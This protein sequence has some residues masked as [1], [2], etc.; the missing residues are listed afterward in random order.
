MTVC[1]AAICERDKN[2]KIVVAGDRMVTYGN[3]EEFEQKEPK[4]IDIAPNCVIA[5]AGNATTPSTILYNAKLSKTIDIVNVREIGNNLLD[6]YFSTRTSEIENKVF[7]RYGINTYKEFLE[8]QK[9]L[10]DDWFLK[11]EEDF[12]EYLFDIQL[13]V[14][15][16]DENGPQLYKIEEG[17]EKLEPLDALGYVMIGIGADHARKIFFICFLRNLSACRSRICKFK[18]DCGR[19]SGFYW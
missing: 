10:R 11:I 1:I 19:L 9:T 14:S 5:T 17:E 18:Q 2:P 7:K 4:L 13:I 12:D 3:I 8:T 6:S 15:G 16:I